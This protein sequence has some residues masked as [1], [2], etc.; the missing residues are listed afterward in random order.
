[1]STQMNAAREGKITDAMKIVAE[2]ENLTAEEIRAGVAKGIIANAN[3][4]EIFIKIF[5]VSLIFRRYKPK[6][7]KIKTPKSANDALGLSKIV[8]MFSNNLITSKKK[9]SEDF[10]AEIFAFLL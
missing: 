10:N 5:V 9:F 6:K 2:K 1:M 3:I 8:N 4:S 7:I